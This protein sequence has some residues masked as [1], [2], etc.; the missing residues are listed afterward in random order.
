MLH[1]PNLIPIRNLRLSY[2][3][4]HI[5]IPV[6]VDSPTS[7]KLRFGEVLVVLRLYVPLLGDAFEGFLHHPLELT[8]RPEGHNEAVV[9]CQDGC[10]TFDKFLDD[11]FAYAGV[12]VHQTQT[13]TATDQM[14]DLGVSIFDAV[15]Q[16]R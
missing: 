14:A 13:C 9:D 15:K 7:V 5:K 16:L 6:S 1:H 8:F 3:I 10:V 12:A 11:V 2:R 4:D